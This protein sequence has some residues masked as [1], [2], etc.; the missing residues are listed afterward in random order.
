MP[1][2]PVDL[3]RQ[4]AGPGNLWS[5]SNL[6]RWA[7]CPYS[8]Y[9]RYILKIPDIPSAPLVQG[10]LCHDTLASALKQ[11]AAPSSWTAAL[12]A[13][14]HH[15]EAQALVPT[16]HDATMVGWIQDAWSQKPDAESVYAEAAWLTPIGLKPD[17]PRPTIALT[18][19]EDVLTSTQKWKWFRAQDVVRDADVDA[20]YAQP[21]WVGVS[22]RHVTVLDWKTSQVKTGY[23][24]ATTAA[25]YAEQLMLYA[26]VARRRFDPEH[27]S[28]A[29]HLLPARTTV[30]LP[31]APQMI[32]QGVKTMAQ[33]IWSIKAAAARG[34]AGFP[35]TPGEACQ[36]CPIAQWPDGC[37]EGAALRKSRGWDR[38]DVTNREERRAVGVHWAGDTT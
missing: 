6:K 32:S 7:D 12:T 35:K 4:I 18:Q 13:A 11:G 19:A 3:L 30:R 2:S 33:R 8:W 25:R 9:G 1:Q 27:V 17:S 23:T 38:F 26:V 5:H 36:Y 37:P 14:R 20:I 21:D 22:G 28:T 29:I 31:M 16:S 34:A 15:T 24:P 10:I